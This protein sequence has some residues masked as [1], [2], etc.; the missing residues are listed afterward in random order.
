MENKLYARRS[1]LTINLIIFAA[2]LLAACQP[3]AAPV[4]Q[5][6]PTKAPAATMPPVP[7]QTPTT[8]ALV[9]A[10][11]SDATV[12][13]AQVNSAKDP[14]YGDI[15]VD[16]KGMTLYIFTKDAPGKVNCSGDCLVKWPPLLT[17][18]T[19]KAGTGVDQA[20]LGTAKLADGSMIVTYN[21]M[22]LYY[23]VNDMKPG[24]ATGQNVG[25]VWFV[26]APDGKII[27]KAPAAASSSGSDTTSQ[28][29]SDD[30]KLRVATDP[31][32][33]EIIVDQNG[34]T[35]YMF[36]KDGPNQSNCAD[37]CL[38]AW[39]PFLDNGKVKAEDGVNAALIGSTTL[40]D[41]S[42]IVTYNKMPLYYWAG[43]TKAGDTSGQ[44]VNSVWYVVSPEGKV[45]GQ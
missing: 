23:W 1:F 42:K 5:I 41:G 25:S 43:D 38:T 6:L 22:P 9:P 31:K 34:M 11:G 15:L 40:P 12:S 10:T 14:Q 20:M 29:D 36:T 17:S 32:L 35:L 7:T 3:T 13:I 30:V 39:P 45:I 18:D 8:A 24:D 28:D 26:I 2:L 19:P 33:G 16:S 21:N 44:G 37:G 27:D 4:Q